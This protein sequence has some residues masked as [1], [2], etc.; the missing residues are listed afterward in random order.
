M[1]V[2]T[3]TSIGS[4]LQQTANAL[5]APDNR[6]SQYLG[7]I[8]L[9]VEQGRT[10]GASLDELVASLRVEL[11][12]LPPSVKEQA[13]HALEGAIPAGLLPEQASV[14]NQAAYDRIA[15]VVQQAATSVL[16]PGLPRLRVGSHAHVGPI[17]YQD[18]LDRVRTGDVPTLV[19]HWVDPNGKDL[20]WIKN[21]AREYVQSTAG[22]AAERNAQLGGAIQQGRPVEKVFDHATV[23]H[24]A[25][26]YLANS[27]F[28]SASKAGSLLLA[29]KI[30]PH[31]EIMEV[32]QR[33]CGGDHER[34]KR[35]VLNPDFQGLRY[36]W[37]SGWLGRRA[38]VV[39]HPNLMD[40]DSVVVI[41]TRS[42]PAGATPLEKLFP[43]DLD[44]A[45]L[46]DAFVQFL[47][48]NADLMPHLDP[49]ATESQGAGA[50]DASVIK[51]VLV[52][53]AQSLG[54][55]SPHA[56]SV[57]PCACLVRQILD[58]TH[59]DQWRVPTGTLEDA[60][61]DE[62]YEKWCAEGPADRA[63]T[64][65][66]MRMFF[67]RYLDLLPAAE[68]VPANPGSETASAPLLPRIKNAQAVMTWAEPY[69]RGLSMEA[70]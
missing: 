54:S 60:K 59:E 53:K 50:G 41:D 27:P 38:L 11:D 4:M 20:D 22:S 2:N 33:H 34:L 62:W 6:A 63:V 58:G 31:Q 5:N 28:N 36:D 42:P 45:G 35:L 40:L 65:G 3:R 47:A 43:A 25:G 55:W 29:M 66:E 46:Q 17:R 57:W 13:A 21:H 26:L 52:N 67:A 19:F 18:G 69:L 68:P 48:Q 10:G 30:K 23:S 70:W 12:R 39:R 37:D 14:G 8:A 9:L 24:G 16:E 32:G 51:G 1:S 64:A 61:G 44:A 7:K 56:D 15:D 49:R